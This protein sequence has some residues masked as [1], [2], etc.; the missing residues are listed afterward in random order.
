MSPSEINATNER[1]MTAFR[2]NSGAH[3][4][5]SLPI[6]DGGR[7]QWIAG[8][9]ANSWLELSTNDE[10][11]Y[12]A[13][14]VQ[15]VQASDGSWSTHPIAPEKYSCPYKFDD[16]HYGTFDSMLAFHQYGLHVALLAGRD[17]SDRGDMTM[18]ARVLDLVS[19]H[20][21][22][23]AKV[24]EM[25]THL[26]GGD[27]AKGLAKL[28]KTLT[29]TSA[30][31]MCSPNDLAK[32]GPIQPWHQAN[33]L[34]ELVYDS[35]PLDRIALHA[36][37]DI[38]GNS[39]AYLWSCPNAINPFGEEYHK[40]LLLD[41]QMQPLLVMSGRAGLNTLTDLSGSE[42][43]WSLPE[44]SKEF[45]TFKQ[46]QDALLHY[47]LNASG[48]CRD[49]VQTSP[50]LLEGPE[51][52]KALNLWVNADNTAMDWDGSPEAKTIVFMSRALAQ[53][54]Q[55]HH[56]QISGVVDVLADPW[57][58]NEDPDQVGRW[59][60]IAR[61]MSRPNTNAQETLA[62]PDLDTSEPAMVK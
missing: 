50:A 28:A 57:E 48:L 44:Y 15:S 7:T 40:Q 34:M 56:P 14:T 62:L 13:Q 29:F 23:L 8:G 9:Q 31:S 35:Q 39:K 24:R 46:W 11:L 51:E 16:M 33:V 38:E 30:W 54:W 6:F 60:N 27:A 19:T 3:E 5:A 17:A 41:A 45:N 61:Q 20:I 10:G 52:A 32:N 49:L 36:F 55:G 18:V 22:W 4:V 53:M 25:S 21:P 59:L 43:E 42:W 47:P 26:H 58:N 37:K 12:Q 2:Y 1:T